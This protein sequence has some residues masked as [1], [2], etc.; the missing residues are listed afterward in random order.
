[1]RE[2]CQP[3]REAIDLPELG[4]VFVQSIGMRERAELAKKIEAG[5]SGFDSA[6]YMLEMMIVEENGDQVWEADSWS[7]W[8]GK[9]LNDFGDLSNLVAEHAGYGVEDAK[10]N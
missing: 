7:V 6:L 5:G 2:P 4:T 1:M 3:N 8:A 9:Y 10:K